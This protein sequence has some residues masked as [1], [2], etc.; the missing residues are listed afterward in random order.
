VPQTGLVVTPRF[1][2]PVDRRGYRIINKRNGMVVA[3]Y[4]GFE[5]AVLG[6]VGRPHTFV[7]TDCSGKVLFPTE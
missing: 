1:G 4:I 5:Q 6:I 7:V 2:F 3:E